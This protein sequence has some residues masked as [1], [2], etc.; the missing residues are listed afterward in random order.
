MQERA[1]SGFTYQKPSAPVSLSVR[2]FEHVVK[3]QSFDSHWH[4]Y[5]TDEDGSP[6]RDDRLSHALETASQQAKLFR[7]VHRN[8]LVYCGSHGRVDAGKLLE[9]YERYLAWK[10]E[11]P[12][13]IA[14]LSGDPLPHHVSLQYVNLSP[15][16]A[17]GLLQNLSF[18]LL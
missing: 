2:P 5:T 16:V 17:F 13:N 12:P 9:I 3:R 7:I 4:S 11:L 15:F 10:E 14:D 1:W 18:F 6:E 8:I